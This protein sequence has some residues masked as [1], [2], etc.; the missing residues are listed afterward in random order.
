MN[1]ARGSNHGC[2]HGHNQG[3]KKKKKQWCARA[4]TKQG[5]IN[6][7]ANMDIAR[8]EVGG[9]RVDRENE[10]GWL[11]VYNAQPTGTVVSRR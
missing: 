3:K 7:S 11:S 6:T 4:W 10:F 8:G 5:G 9:R 1:I 2:E